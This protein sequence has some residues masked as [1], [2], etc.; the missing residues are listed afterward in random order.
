MVD[1]KKRTERM[2]EELRKKMDLHIKAGKE[3][4]ASGK[5]QFPL[6]VKLKAALPL[7][8]IVVALYSW[9]Y[10]YMG[11]RMNMKPDVAQPDKILTDVRQIFAPEEK[12][13]GPGPADLPASFFGLE[14]KD[15]TED[16]NKRW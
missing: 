5:P 4:E 11:K 9:S 16:Q 12:T 6:S 2:R 14:E 15:L 10:Y 3:A 8:A 1:V 13:G 7:V